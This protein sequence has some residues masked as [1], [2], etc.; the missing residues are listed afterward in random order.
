MWGERE[1]QARRNEGRMGYRVSAGQ[2][3]A[4][5]ER[6]LCFD[7]GCQ[8]RQATED[9]IWTDVIGKVCKVHVRN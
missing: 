4:A 7:T 9:P 2:Q 1:E 8:L 5:P 3:E 6:R